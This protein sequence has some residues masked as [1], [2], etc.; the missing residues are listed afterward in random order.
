MSQSLVVILKAL[1]HHYLLLGRKANKSK[2]DEKNAQAAHEAMWLQVIPSMSSF[3]KLIHLSKKSQSEL[4]ANNIQNLFLFYTVTY[5]NDSYF[6]TLSCA[7]MLLY[8]M[9]FNLFN[10]GLSSHT[11]RNMIFDLSWTRTSKNQVSFYM[12]TRC[13]DMFI[14]KHVLPPVVQARVLNSLCIWRCSNVTAFQWI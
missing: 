7:K 5:C 2:R 3:D 10:S 12:D 8:Y 4:R 9:Y 11:L 13:L 1:S 14:F 6:R